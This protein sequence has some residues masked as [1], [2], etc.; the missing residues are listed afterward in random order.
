MSIDGD[1]IPSH[2]RED[3]VRAQGHD[4]DDINCTPQSLHLSPSKL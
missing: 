2:G 1:S 4:T 3:D